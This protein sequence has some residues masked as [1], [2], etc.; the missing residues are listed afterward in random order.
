[1]TRPRLLNLSLYAPLAA[2]SLVA[3]ALIAVGSPL[4]LPVAIAASAWLSLWFGVSALFEAQIAAWLDTP[5]SQ[6]RVDAHA[7]MLAE[8]D[9]D[10]AQR[11]AR[12][13]AMEW[14]EVR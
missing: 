7:A 3:L 4:W 1:M 12:D 6:A 8:Y 11:R 14:M 9:A 10:M 2:L 5:A 13:E